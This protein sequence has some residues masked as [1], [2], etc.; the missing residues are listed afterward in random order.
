MCGVFRAERSSYHYRSR[1][2]SQAALQKRIREIAET[3]VRYGYR[4]IH[5]LLQREGWAV[6]PI[7][8]IGSTRKKGCNSGILRRVERRNRS[9]R[10]LGSFGRIERRPPARTRSGRWTSCRISSLTG[11]AYGCSRSSMRL[12]VS[13]RRSTSDRGT[14]ARMSWRRSSVSP[15][16]M[17]SPRPFVWITGRNLSARTSTS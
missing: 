12:P 6:I 15:V 17:A 3:R 8:P 16:S 13:V 1:R 4:R 14:G 11:D 9:G 5:V 2:P 10:S 7:V